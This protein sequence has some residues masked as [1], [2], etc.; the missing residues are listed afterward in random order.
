MR[1]GVGAGGRDRDLDL[2]SARERRVTDRD[3]RAVAEVR[4]KPCEALQWFGP[5]H[6]RRVGNANVR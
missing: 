1:L 5:G 2:D 3:L 6:G 4:V